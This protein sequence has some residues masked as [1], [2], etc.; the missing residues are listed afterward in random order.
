MAVDGT[1]RVVEALR[2]RGER[3]DYCIVGEPTCV[4]AAGR[5][6]QERPA[7]LALRRRCACAACRAT[8][9]IR[10]WR[11]IRCIR[12]RP[13]WP[14][15]AAIQWDD[16]NEYFPPTTLQISNIQAGTG[17][18]N[19]IPGELRVLFNFRFSTA[20][21]VEGLKARVHERAGPARARLCAR[22]VAVRHAVPHPA[23]ANWWRPSARRSANELG[24]EP[25]LSTTR[26]HFGWTFHRRHLPAGG[27]ARPGQRVDPPGQ[28]AR[29]AGRRGCT[30]RVYHRTL[31]AL[32]AWTLRQRS[33]LR[34]HPRSAALRGEP[35]QR[36]RGSRSATARDNAY[37]EAA[38]LILHTLHLPLDRLEPFLD[39]T[40]LPSENSSRC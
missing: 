15:C 17:A 25:E 29:C 28:R 20:S 32:A 38:Y 31:A 6:D 24:I 30:C 2:A 33:S 27:R 35:V 16:G 13:R 11:A 14:S 1:V 39:A 36:T 40:L 7:R 4:H 34:T 23:R 3:L 37:D 5:H 10:I 9:P 21:T 8:S 22:V 18:T 19:V 26:R 12:P